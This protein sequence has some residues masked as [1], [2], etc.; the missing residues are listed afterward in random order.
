MIFIY[1]EGEIRA[2]RYLFLLLEVIFIAITATQQ[3]QKPKVPLLNCHHKK[4]EKQ[5]CTNT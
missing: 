2:L 4:L 5:D 1:V 3:Y